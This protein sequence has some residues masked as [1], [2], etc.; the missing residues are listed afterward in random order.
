MFYPIGPGG[1]A[2][3][4]SKVWPFAVGDRVRLVRDVERFPFFCAR[5]G[6]SGVVVGADEFLRVRM[7]EHIPEASDWDN[8]IIWMAADERDDAIGDL[9]RVEA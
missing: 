9:V 8:C 7:E 3:A 6:L 2:V 5:A 1:A 4:P